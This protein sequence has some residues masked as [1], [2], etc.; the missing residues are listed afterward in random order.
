MYHHI[1]VP[2]DC[3]EEAHR[4]AE[5][6]VPIVLKNSVCRV[7]VVTTYSPATD[8]T[9]RD[10]NLQ[11]ARAAAKEITDV[12]FDYGIVAWRRILGTRNPA[13]AIAE[14]SRRDLCYDLIVLGTHQT[15]T[16]RGEMVEIR[17]TPCQS[18]LATQI[19]ERVDIPVMILPDREKRQKLPG[20]TG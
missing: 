18:P 3:T 17:E 14:E 2:V 11:H 10:H 1:L 5:C 8:P 16:E 7:T 4:V 6:L 13:Q 9:I 12:L 15:R 19:A 20:N